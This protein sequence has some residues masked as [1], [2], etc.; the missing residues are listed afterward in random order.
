VGGEGR[1]EAAMMEGTP[2]LSGYSLKGLLDLKLEVERQLEAKRA[3]T[4]GSCSPR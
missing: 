4:K 2:N 3:E 1:G